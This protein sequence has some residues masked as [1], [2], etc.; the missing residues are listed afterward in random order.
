VYQKRVAG[1][2]AEVEHCKE[3]HHLREGNPAVAKE[4]MLN[5]EALQSHSRILRPLTQV[6]KEKHSF[7]RMLDSQREEAL[8]SIRWVQTK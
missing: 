7:E 4:K 8:N 2:A 1:Q 5:L 6:A 3:G